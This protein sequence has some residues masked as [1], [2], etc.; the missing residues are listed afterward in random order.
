MAWFLVVSGLFLMYLWTRHKSVME[1]E[2]K[3]ND[4]YYGYAVSWK[5]RGAT[6][7]L[8]SFLLGIAMLLGGE[9]GKT[10]A[11]LMFIVLPVALIV[12]GVLVLVSAR[13][14]ALMWRVFR[15]GTNPVLDRKS[16]GIW[17]LIIGLIWLSIFT[18]LSWPYG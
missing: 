8:L 18:Y 6:F 2:L 11:S 12:L 10:M 1:Q 16:L 3:P 13:V 5:V 9:D 7:G 17:L 14:N 4:P 15:R